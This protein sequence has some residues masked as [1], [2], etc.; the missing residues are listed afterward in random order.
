MRQVSD[1]LLTFA[2][3]RTKATAFVSR[4]WALVNGYC[5]HKA[6]AAWDF[7]VNLIRQIPQETDAV[8]HQLQE[9]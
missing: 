2:F 3:S 7:T 5:L 4:G 9:K 6:L 8:L 1:L